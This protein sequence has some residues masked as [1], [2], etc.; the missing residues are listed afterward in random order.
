M[1]LIAFSC[2]HGCLVDVLT[3]YAL[4]D[5][6]GLFDST[7]TTEQSCAVSST[8]TIRTPVDA[9][10]A[11]ARTSAAIQR[12]PHILCDSAW[13]LECSSSLEGYEVSNH[14]ICVIRKLIKQ[15]VREVSDVLNMIKCDKQYRCHDIKRCLRQTT[16]CCIKLFGGNAASLLRKVIL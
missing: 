8:T 15:R 12:T 6:T 16:H 9:A 7:T 3:R 14:S 2:H 11:G 13:F 5:Q 1:T 10:S 4:R